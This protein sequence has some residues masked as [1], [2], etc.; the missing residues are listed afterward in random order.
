MYGARYQPNACP[1]ARSDRPGSAPANAGSSSSESPANRGR[2]GSEPPSPESPPLGFASWGSPVRARHAPSGFMRDRGPSSGR[3][4]AATGSVA[5]SWQPLRP[6]HHQSCRCARRPAP[7]ADSAAAAA[8]SG[9]TSVRERERANRSGHVPSGH[10][11]EEPQTLEGRCAIW[12]HHMVFRQPAPA[13]AMALDRR[14][15]TGVKTGRRPPRLLRS[16]SAPLTEGRDSR[17]GTA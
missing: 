12:K 13:R 8:S 4:D 14:N 15:L 7:L 11:V 2:S 1:T 17:P 16:V 3:R 9:D 5:A 6:W 10:L